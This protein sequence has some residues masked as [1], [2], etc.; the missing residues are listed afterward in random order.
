MAEKKTNVVFWA[1]QGPDDI[2][3][4]SE[5]DDL[6][7]ITSVTVPE[8]AVALFIRD[9]QLAG[10]LDPGRHTVT[11]ANIPWLSKLYNAALGYKET[12][13]KVWIV[14]VSLK[15]FN[16]KWGIRSMIKAAKEYE[17]PIVLMANGD[18]QFRINDISVFYTQV[19]GGLN[20]YSTGDVNSFM[21][22][23][24]N[25][26]IIQQM[27]TQYYMDIMENLEKASTNTKILIEHYFAQRGIELL[28]LKINE[29]LTTDEDR[30]KVFSYLQFSSKNG[31]AF[32]R[33]EVMERMADAI[34]DS[35]GGAAMGAGMLLF[36]QM[37]QQLQQQPVQGVVHQQQPT[38]VMCPTC[39]G[40]N[41]YPYKY[42][43]SCGQPSPMISQ[44]QQPAQV[45]AS[46]NI[47]GNPEASAGNGK[48]FKNC[49][50]CGEDLGGLPKTPKYCPYCS[51]QLN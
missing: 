33:Y 11:S 36:P 22:S 21:K 4:R 42:C 8:H 27:N 28:S 45:Q 5:H 17:V 23:F 39:G 1:N 31:E 51:E 29:V 10:T 3:Y 48:K 40:L 30:Q 44:G 15:M 25:E 49:P 32:K 2:I 13:F 6:R 26:Q 16:G 41:D 14:F 37:Y 12:P 24:I 7:T 20:T 50:Y 46:Q 43:S 35:T 38:K 9:G 18:F 47:A 34:G 19:L